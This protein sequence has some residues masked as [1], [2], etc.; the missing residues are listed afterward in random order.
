MHV[1]QS[2]MTKLTHTFTGTIRYKLFE[3]VSR[4]LINLPYRFSA[5]LLSQE[6]IQAGDVLT[7]SS[8]VIL[9][10]TFY[11]YFITYHRCSLPF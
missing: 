11:N 5:Y 1:P 4:Y 9:V 3:A 7:V 10:I 2:C 8:N 6:I